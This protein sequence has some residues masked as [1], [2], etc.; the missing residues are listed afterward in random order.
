MRGVSV[1]MNF[2]LLTRKSIEM[3]PSIG[4][5]ALT[6][7]SISL[8]GCSVERTPL[9]QADHHLRYGR[10]DE[11]IAESKSAIAQ[12]N[13]V[14]EKA[15]GL[16]IIGR[17]HMELA[18]QNNGQAE[19][20]HL[21]QAIDYFSQSIEVSDNA[22]ARHGRRSAYR[23]TGQTEL[24][25][26][27]YLRIRQIDPDYASAY[28]NEKPEV[29]RDYS[30]L[31]VNLLEEDTTTDEPD[32]R[33][34][35]ADEFDEDEELAAPATGAIVNEATVLRPQPATGTGDSNE[36]PSEASDQPAPKSGRFSDWLTQH[37]QR[38][39]MP[40]GRE[41]GRYDLQRSPLL[42]DA[43]PDADEDGD[44][45]GSNDQ[46]L[47]QFPSAGIP[48][49]L[50]PQGNV[51]P[52]GTLPTTGIPTRGL[53]GT[54]IPT[55]GFPTSSNLP[56]SSVPSTGIGGVPLGT[57]V[58]ST[59]AGV[60]PNAPT[61]GIGSAPLSPGVATPGITTPGTSPGISVPGITTPLRPSTSGVFL[62]NRNRQPGASLPNNTR[63][64][65]TSPAPSAGIP[66]HLAPPAPAPT[67]GFN[68]NQ[69][70]GPVQFQTSPRGA[71]QSG[72]RIPTNPAPALPIG[73]QPR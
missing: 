68:F 37:Q 10:F 73:P 11:A 16:L 4:L 52:Q 69:R 27:D 46:P 65:V 15:E 22:E 33:T 13:T 51:D 21:S 6:L 72:P 41:A 8:F 50:A 25:A 38:T 49:S 43:D 44:A 53:P 66:A 35:E 23:K 59:Y 18:N 67:N 40:N 19:T 20:D 5:F 30:D 28:V 24:A 3:K 57:G 2:R 55:T 39:A 47:T 48:E 9:E 14:E 17:C 7:T 64:T 56:G 34:S 1:F 31:D 26:E 32:R 71:P 63:N 42:D 36:E 45:S 62:P 61:T 12:A 60:L 54:S 29:L 58:G 70:L